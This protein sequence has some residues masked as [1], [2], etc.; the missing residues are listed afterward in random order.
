MTV[1]DDIFTFSAYKK[2][3]LDL[4]E[5][6]IY[7]VLVCII[8]GNISI[9]LSK[10]SSSNLISEFLDLINN[11][12]INVITSTKEDYDPY[13]KLQRNKKIKEIL[14]QFCTINDNNIIEELNTDNELI[15]KLVDTGSDTKIKFD[16]VVNKGDKNFYLVY[17]KIDEKFIKNFLQK[18]LDTF[19]DCSTFYLFFSYAYL[20]LLLFSL[21]MTNCYIYFLNILTSIITERGL[22]LV[23]VI[24]DLL[25][26]I[27]AAIIFAI[28]ICFM[29]YFLYYFFYNILF[30]VYGCY[31]PFLAAYKK[32]NDTYAASIGGTITWGLSPTRFSSF[33][34]WFVTVFV[35]GLLWL[36]LFCL[37]IMGYYLFY[38]IVVSMGVFIVVG[39]GILWVCLS[40]IRG[41]FVEDCEPNTQSPSNEFYTFTGDKKF[42]TMESISYTYLKYT[43]TYYLLYV[44]FIIYPTTQKVF[45]SNVIV[46]FLIFA[47]ICYY[48][49]YKVINKVQTNLAE[50]YN[51]STASGANLTPDQLVKVMNKNPSFGQGIFAYLKQYFSFKTE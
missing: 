14:E 12:I 17:Y 45:G 29:I 36:V 46:P 33:M 8:C 39:Y 11:N 13:E 35:W 6:T 2:Y 25:Q 1:T 47:C 44:I 21:L 4:I 20:Q 24:N 5:N 10:I 27:K 48:F 22:L 16:L 18:I 37:G 26:W 19:H 49:I 23:F 40:C 7:F 34:L 51:N 41:Y 43:L 31:Q 32:A 3:S 38:M 15:N 28:S 30:L 42:N 9:C 50:M